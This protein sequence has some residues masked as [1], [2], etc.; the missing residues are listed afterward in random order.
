MVTPRSGTCC[1]NQFS[2]KF[3]NAKFCLDM[4]KPK[5]YVY[6]VG[7]AGGRLLRARVPHMFRRAV[8]FYTV[9]P[10]PGS[11]GQFV[12]KIVLVIWVSET[13]KCSKSLNSFVP[14]RFFVDVSRSWL[15]VR[16]VKSKNEFAAAENL[17]STGVGHVTIFF[18]K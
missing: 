7:L 15:S 17:S 12:V 18:E 16:V 2:G 1:K 5:G 9:I 13:A 4:P 3:E 11:L 8:L 6:F 14:T 10:S